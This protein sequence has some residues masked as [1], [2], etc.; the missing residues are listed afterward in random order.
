MTKHAPETTP[1]FNC[2]CSPENGCYDDP[3][4]ECINA[5]MCLGSDEGVAHQERTMKAFFN[6][7]MPQ[8]VKDTP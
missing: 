3:R 2:V 4:G 7:L 1:G 6:W 8:F 5:G